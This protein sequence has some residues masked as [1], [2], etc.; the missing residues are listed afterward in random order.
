MWNKISILFSAKI[1]ITCQKCSRE[2]S[3]H[4][5]DSDS[6]DLALHPEN[7]IWRATPL[8]PMQ[9]HIWLFINYSDKT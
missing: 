4:M 7:M 2:I 1:N 6:F 9:P 8:E 3:V 5:Q